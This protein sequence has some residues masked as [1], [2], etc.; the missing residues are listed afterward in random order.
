MLVIATCFSH[1]GAQIN[2]IFE[3]NRDRVARVA[4][5]E[6]ANFCLSMCQLLD[7]SESLQT[8]LTTE[9]TPC[10]ASLVCNTAILRGIYHLLMDNKLSQ[11]LQAMQV[12][13]SLDFF[14]PVCTVEAHAMNVWTEQPPYW[15]NFLWSKEM[16]LVI[17]SDK[18]PL[19][20]PAMS[21]NTTYRP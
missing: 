8:G 15:S 14:I 6:P 12:F 2:G 10:F 17:E 4:T 18:L 3:A 9:C 19:L 16:L 13:A 11:Q 7:G 1:A 20:K 5:C 21:I